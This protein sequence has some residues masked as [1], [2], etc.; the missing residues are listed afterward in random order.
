M[1]EEVVRVVVATTAPAP[2]PAPSATARHRR[3]PVWTGTSLVVLL[4]LTTVLQRVLVPPGTPP[5][6]LALVLVY[7]A[8]ALLL[9]AGHLR[10]DRVRLELFGVAAVAV[11]VASVAATAT[12]GVISVTSLGLLLVLWA[13]WVLRV[14]PGHHHVARRVAL[15]FVNLMVVL[16]AVGV[17]MLAVQLAGLW[18][19]ED[20]PSSWVPGLLQAGFNTSDPIFFGSP[21]WKSNAFV[22]LEP[23]TFSQYCALGAIVSVVLR[24]AAWKLLV[25]ALGIASTISGTG[26]MLLGLGLLIALVRAPRLVRPGA[27]VAAGAAVVAVA[28]TPLASL[29]VGRVDE[30][31]QVGSSGYLRFVQPYTEVLAGLEAEPV[32]YLVGAGPG[33]VQ[34][35]LES[36]RGESVGQAVLYSIIPKAIFEY[37]VVAGGLFVL[38]IVL[39]VLDRSPWPVVPGAVLVLLLFLGGNLLQPQLVATA[40]LLTSLFADQPAPRPGGPARGRTG[41]SSPREPLSRQPSRRLTGAP[42][43]PAPTAAR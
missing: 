21:V 26:I 35:L 23:S 9:R 30:P 2:A 16:A 41:R 12:G 36:G 29:I 18:T 40:W 5:V 4:V 15:A 1:V 13:P 27:L 17:L 37:G 38:F 43:G 8:V 22:F 20:Y 24:Q 34:R 3:A 10:V 42:A 19:Y 11:L 6:A 14:A 28:F 7:G 32:R 39:A 25:L 33:A 31:T